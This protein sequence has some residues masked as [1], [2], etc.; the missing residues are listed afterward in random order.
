MQAIYLRLYQTCFIRTVKSNGKTSRKLD[1]HAK[2]G[3]R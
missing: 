2:N 1:S 3:D